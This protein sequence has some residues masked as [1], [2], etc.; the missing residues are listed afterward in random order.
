MGMIGQLGL[1]FAIVTFMQIA[2]PHKIK[3]SSMQLLKNSLINFVIE[4]Y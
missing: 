3:E 2:E 4:I 1:A